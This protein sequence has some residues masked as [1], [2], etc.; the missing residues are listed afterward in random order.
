MSETSSS[1]RDKS[2]NTDIHVSMLLVVAAAPTCVMW[3]CYLMYC[4]IKRRRVEANYLRTDYYTGSS[5]NITRHSISYE[6]VDDWVTK[7]CLLIESKRKQSPSS[8]ES[9]VLER[10]LRCRDPQNIWDA[11]QTSTSCDTSVCFY[12]PNNSLSLKN[13]NRLSRVKKRRQKTRRLRSK[14]IHDFMK[15]LNSNKRKIKYSRK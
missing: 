10:V 12:Q 15:D 2:P 14:T 4:V 13:I 5:D 3:L 7:S 8:E 1:T 6:N 11:E 9:W